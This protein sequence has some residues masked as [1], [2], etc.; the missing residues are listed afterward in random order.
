[1]RSDTEVRQDVLNELQRDPAVNE[2][3]IGVTVH[4]GI[5]TL[6]G[7]ASS[8]GEKRAAEQAALRVKGVNAIAEGIEVKSP[9]STVH[10]DADIAQ[11]VVN[12][13]K[14]TK[15]IQEEIDVK[16]E[17]GI[18]TLNGDVRWKFERDLA[19]GAVEN[20]AGVRG[21]INLVSML[22]QPAAAKVKEEIRNAFE[23]AALLDAAQLQV[24]THE[25]EVTLKG[26]VHSMA[27]LRDAEYAAWA[28]PGVTEVTNQLKVV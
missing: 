3:E 23:R 15:G 13:L 5:V 28:G 8:Y 10:S 14:R 2:N 4:K 1:M 7:Y 17:D 26:N 22:E 19:K 9:T 16:V 6:T 12:A 25:G 27:E 21:V 20:L 11:A 18:V 24:E